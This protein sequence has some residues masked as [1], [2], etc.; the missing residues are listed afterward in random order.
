MI[1]QHPEIVPDGTLLWMAHHAPNPPER[2]PIWNNKWGKE[3][4]HFFHSGSQA[5]GNKEVWIEYHVRFASVLDQFLENNLFI[6]ED[7]CVLQGTCQKY[8][9]LCAYIAATDVADDYYFGLRYA[10]HHGSTSSNM[11]TKPWQMPGAKK[12]QTNL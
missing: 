1:V 12:T 6:G 4:V 9:D 5:A 11:T 2:G 10:L 3:A 7:Q 8:P